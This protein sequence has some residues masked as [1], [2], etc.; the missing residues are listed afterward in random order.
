LSTRI[1]VAHASTLSEEG[2]ATEVVVVPGSW[3][4]AVA[5]S[6]AKIA[7]ENNTDI[8]ARR[9]RSFFIKIS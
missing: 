9:R 4:S 5:V 8:L 2:D 7:E 6:A 1:A 3:I